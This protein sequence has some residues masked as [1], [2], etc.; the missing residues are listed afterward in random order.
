M[1]A[2]RGVNG[3]VQVRRSCPSSP[4]WLQVRVPLLLIGARSR[5]SCCSRR[6]TRVLA[7]RS[8]LRDFL[9]VDR[10]RAGHRVTGLS[11]R[12]R[13]RSERVTVDRHVFENGSLGFEASSTHLS[14]VGD[15]R[16]SRVPGHLDLDRVFRRR[17][18]QRPT[19]ST[20]K[21]CRVP[22][23]RGPGSTIDDDGERAEDDTGDGEPAATVLH[24]QSDDA[25]IRAMMPRTIDTLLTMGIAQPTIATMPTIRAT[26]PNGPRL[27]WSGVGCCW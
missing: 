26:R 7:G 12:R 8:V 3:T 2:S 5:V 13:D 21:H 14:G 6:T 24:D 9:A 10:H 1:T 27:W 18:P 17:H 11:V 16:V 23:S 4:Q 20:S 15:V 19:R 25:K 22:M